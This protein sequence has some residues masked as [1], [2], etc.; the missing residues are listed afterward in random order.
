[1]SV[2]TVFIRGL[3]GCSLPILVTKYTTVYEIYQHLLDLGVVPK[4]GINNLFFTVGG[5]RV[6]WDD[7]MESLKLGPISHLDLRIR[8][9][10]GANPDPEASSSSLPAKRKRNEKRMQNILTAEDQ[11]SD[12]NPE[13]NRPKKSARKSRK[14]KA[15][16]DDT[17]KTDAEDNDFSSGSESD[18]DSD[19]EL[20]MTNEELADSLLAK[21]VVEG[22]R[23]K[24][25]QPV[26]PTKNPAKSKGKG[27]GKAM[28]SEPPVVIPDATAESNTDTGSSKAAKKKPGRS[29]IYL[30][31]ELVA[32]DADGSQLE[33]ARYYKCYLGNRTII[34]ITAGSNYNTKS[35]LNK[36]FKGH[37]RLYEVLT[38]RDGLPTADGLALINGTQAMDAAT[39]IKYAQQADQLS[40]NI[41]S[42]FQKQ[43]TEAEASVFY[44]FDP[45]YS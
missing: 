15:R 35:S 3:G 1:M 2:F 10:G 16:R 18:S 25:S 5:R 21:T 29:P 7:T 8:V 20:V 34:S 23:R 30:L 17:A 33:G 12:G 36:N 42:I 40:Q 43:A 27:K 28:V 37:F 6:S 44:G 26:K 13:G 22:S 4:T 24:T 31:Y 32:Q 14:K 39:A 38:R 45:E 11:D 9:P 19:V 41:K